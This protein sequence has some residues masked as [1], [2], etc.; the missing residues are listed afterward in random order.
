MR[1]LSAIVIDWADAFRAAWQQTGMNLPQSLIM[2]AM[3]IGRQWWQ[4]IRGLR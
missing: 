1:L 3:T 2:C 4:A